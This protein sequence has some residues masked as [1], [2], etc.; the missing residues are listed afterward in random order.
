MMNP[1]TE[2]VLIVFGELEMDTGE[3][4]YKICLNCDGSGTIR[5]VNSCCIADS[6][7]I[8][9]T[10][11]TFATPLRTDLKIVLKTV[12]FSGKKT[13]WLCERYKV[14]GNATLY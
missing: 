8:V 9:S 4:Y 7:K 2:D 12:C 14:L 1:D 10:S 3:R 11:C 13:I 5:L 6:C